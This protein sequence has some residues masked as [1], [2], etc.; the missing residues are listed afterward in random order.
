MIN[1]V[2]PCSSTPLHQ[3]PSTLTITGLSHPRADPRPRPLATPLPVLLRFLPLVAPSASI[4]SE[5]RL[6]SPQTN[7]PTHPLDTLEEKVENCDYKDFSS[8]P[9]PPF[10][11]ARD[12]SSF[13]PSFLLRPFLRRLN[14]EISPA[15]TRSSPLPF[16]L[17]SPRIKTLTL[18]YPFSEGG[19]EEGN[20][21][22]PRPVI[23]GYFRRVGQISNSPPPFLEFRF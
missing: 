2:N 3:P 7:Q 17:P 6:T 12:D 22:I 11:L 4:Q 20:G 9:P 13:L 23:R 21:S 5:S 16:F 14:P 1:S 8:L 19:M 15:V 10:R 18:C